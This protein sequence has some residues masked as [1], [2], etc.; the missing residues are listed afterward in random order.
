MGTC[1]DG[2]LANG[3]QWCGPIRRFEKYFDL[4]IELD[5]HP[6][7]PH[8]RMQ[9]DQFAANQIKFLFADRRRRL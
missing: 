9:L 2:W 5:S 3:W 6:H 4:R 7:H 8:R 1:P